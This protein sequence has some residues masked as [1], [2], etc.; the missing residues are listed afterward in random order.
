MPRVWPILLASLLTSACHTARSKPAPSVES[1]LAQGRPF[2]AEVAMR[3]S[4]HDPLA[5][6]ELVLGRDNLK[7]AELL[8]RTA[9][10]ADPINERAQLLLARAQERHGEFEAAVPVFQKARDLV[11]LCRAALDANQSPE[12]C[13]ALQGK[14]ELEAVSA[15][16]AW[17]LRAG[18]PQAAETELRQALAHVHEAGPEIRTVSRL[19]YLL[20]LALRDQHH[21]SEAEPEFWRTLAIQREVLGGSLD[22]AD[23]LYA[24][25]AMKLDQ[26][27][28]ASFEPFLRE[29]LQIRVRL[30]DANDWRV[31][32]ARGAVAACVSAER[33]VVAG[34]ASDLRQAYEAVARARGKSS[35][36]ALQ[37]QVWFNAS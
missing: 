4:P 10:R 19:H 6:G 36:E 35:P 30:L 9:L 7:E 25:G 14:T 24:L 16:T 3:A 23:T 31:A 13:K 32:Q 18:Q 29:A 17:L 26:G 37:L 27:W 28:P 2:E 11:W 12:V 34:A 1:L 22:I 8:A 5:Y 21:P 15:Y 33:R 20:A